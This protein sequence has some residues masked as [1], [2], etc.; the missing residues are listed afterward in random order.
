MKKLSLKDLKVSSFITK[1]CSLA[2]RGGV[3]VD[4]IPIE[5]CLVKTANCPDTVGGG[6]CASEFMSDCTGPCCEF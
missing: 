5:Y 4:T 2:T 1:E 3:D 6:A